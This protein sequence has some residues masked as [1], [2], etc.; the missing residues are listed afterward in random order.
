MTME[1]WLEWAR[2]PVFKFAFVVMALGLLRQFLIAIA[3]TVQAL[4]R[5]GDKNIPY[6]VVWRTTLDWLFP[7]KKIGGVNRPLYSAISV[8]FHIGMILTPIFLLPHILLWKRGL[9]IAWPSL[10]HALADLLTLLTIA[11]AIALFIGRLGHTEARR[12]SR[13]Q[14]LLLPL[15]IMVPFVTGFFAMHPSINPVD[16]NA[17]MF[18]HV[19]SANLIFLLIPFTKLGHIILLPTTQLV[20]EVGWHFPA[21]SGD[22]VAIALKKENMPI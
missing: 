12:I 1:Q 7:L 15:L 10:P 17:V 9:G 3:G 22:D 16:Y 4:Y 13:M 6:K 14:D 2:G 8:V 21:E 20:S 19:M 5:A 18:I 11:S